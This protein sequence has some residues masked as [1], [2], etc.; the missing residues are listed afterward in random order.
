MKNNRKKANI[1]RFKTRRFHYVYDV[2]TSRFFKVDRLSYY[3]LGEF[4]KKNKNEILNAFSSKYPIKEVSKKIKEIDQLASKRNYFSNL[5]PKSIKRIE[6]KEIKEKCENY[7]SHLTLSITEQCNMRCKYCVYS[8][9]YPY[10]RGHSKAKMPEDTAFKAIDFFF[11]HSLKTENISI[12]FYGGEPLIYYPLL[13]KCVYYANRLNE[14]YKKNLIFTITTNGTLLNDEIVKFLIRNRI[15]LAISLDGPKEIHDRYR[16]F[17][18][19]KGSYE[20]V[21]KN[22]MKLK[23]I[24]HKYFKK[25]VNYNVVVT[26]PYEFFKLEKFFNENDEIFVDTYPFINFVID[27]NTDF[28]MKYSQDTQISKKSLKLKN[29]ILLGQYKNMITKER[30][31]KFLEPIFNMIFKKI[32]LRKIYPKFE[33]EYSF[34]HLCIPGASKLLVNSNGKF[35][36]CTNVSS[37]M[38]IGNIHKGFDYN[39]IK[40]LYNKYIDLTYDD[41]R[42]CWAIRICNACYYSAVKG[43]TFDL[44]QK[45]EICTRIKKRV[46]AM[47]IIYNEILEDNEQAFDYLFPK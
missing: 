30:K 17:K 6:F 42:N 31:N 10:D 47:F 3:I 25:H 13:R 2:G 29:E 7:C 46:K 19:G 15:G 4:Y 16:V 24:D 21:L 44:S 18:Q 26:P 45:R 23:D 28:V 5:I 35:H 38:S 20:A 40:Q 11:K 14:K 36:Y 41:C 33:E 39:K 34:N 8:S 1:L 43:D 12:G 9:S 37:S 32:H 22:L 27:L